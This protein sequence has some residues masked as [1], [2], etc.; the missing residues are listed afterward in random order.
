MRFCY[1]KLHH[2]Y[3]GLNTKSEI[4]EALKGLIVVYFKGNIDCTPFQQNSIPV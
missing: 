4:I 1:T 3:V 2:T